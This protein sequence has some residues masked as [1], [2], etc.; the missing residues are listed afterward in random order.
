MLTILTR[1]LEDAM[2]G[3][4]FPPVGGISPLLRRGSRGDRG[5]LAA[6]W[7]FVATDSVV[8]FRSDSELC[9]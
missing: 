8:F 5:Q 7:I 4:D 1:L 3:E 2:G 9:A 6:L